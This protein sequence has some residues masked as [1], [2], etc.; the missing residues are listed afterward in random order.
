MGERILGRDGEGDGKGR[1]I[2][3]IFEGEE[4]GREGTVG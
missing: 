3:G 4:R 1:V 2:V